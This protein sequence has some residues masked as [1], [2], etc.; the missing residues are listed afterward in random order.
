MCSSSDFHT[1]ITDLSDAVSLVEFE[2]FFFFFDMKSLKTKKLHDTLQLFLTGNS[3]LA[4]RKG[5]KNFQTFH[6]LSFAFRLEK[7][8]AV[9]SDGLALTYGLVFCTQSF[10]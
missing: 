8:L 2:S 9:H 4:Q 1:V 10:P 6:C 3:V 5:A 7:P